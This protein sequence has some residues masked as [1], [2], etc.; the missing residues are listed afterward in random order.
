VI[1][2][3]GN[4]FYRVRDMDAAVHFYAEVL[5]LPLKFRDGDRWAAF[6]VSGVTLALEGSAATSRGGGAT[7][8]LR[9]KDLDR[10]VAELRQRGADVGEITTG[11]HERRADLRDPS[12]NTLVLYEPISR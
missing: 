3:I 4:V 7:V 11:P 9:I 12:G 2:R 10:L 8:S 6:D 5:G 1:E